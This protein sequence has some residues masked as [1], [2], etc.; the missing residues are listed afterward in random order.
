MSENGEKVEVK[1]KVTESLRG[2][3]SRIQPHDGYETLGY[4]RGRIVYPLG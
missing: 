1:G 2:P 4:L 3:M